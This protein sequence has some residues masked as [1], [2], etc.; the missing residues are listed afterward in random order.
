[1]WELLKNDTSNVTR[2][3]NALV[4]AVPP[5]G[6]GVDEGFIT[7]ACFGN[8]ACKVSCGL[9]PRIVVIRS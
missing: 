4:D 8:R 5:S 2:E 6:L 1:M 3:T 9:S 7:Y